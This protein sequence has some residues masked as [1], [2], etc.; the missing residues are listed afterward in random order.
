MLTNFC[1]KFK[2]HIIGLIVILGIALIC[3][4][5]RLLTSSASISSLDFS[6][7][8]EIGDTIGGITA[9]IVGILSIL[10]LFYT[11][12]EQIKLN[13]EQIEFNN[14]QKNYNDSQ[15]KSNELSQI[16]IVQNQIIHLLNT[17]SISASDLNSQNKKFD[18]IYDLYIIQGKNYK[19]NSIEFE[20]CFHQGVEIL[21]T[22]NLFLSLINNSSLTKEQKEYLIAST[23]TTHIKTASFFFSH[24]ISVGIDC[25]DRPIKEKKYYIEQMDRIISRKNYLI[26]V[27]FQS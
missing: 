16:L 8:G 13:K 19:F 1:R 12:I 14:K 23:G 24:Q 26:N 3:I 11:L 21:S 20:N 6:H 27:F 7:T 5:P 15:I 4:F 22:Y 10:L 18:S 9:P 25:C 17:F 2:S